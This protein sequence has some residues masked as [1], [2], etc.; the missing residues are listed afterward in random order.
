MSDLA[1]LF[2]VPGDDQREH[3]PSIARASSIFSAAPLQ[4]KRL[5]PSPVLDQVAGF[6]SRFSLSSLRF[7]ASHSGR[8]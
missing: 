5:Q 6:S 7:D 2:S 1:S 3:R 4:Q 8:S